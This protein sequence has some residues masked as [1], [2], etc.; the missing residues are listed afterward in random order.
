MQREARPVD[1]CGFVEIVVHAHL[2]EIRRG[3]L[4]VEELVL[5]DEEFA[6]LAGHAQR[7][8]IV[9]DVAPAIVRDQPIGCGEIKTGLPFRGRHFGLRDDGDLGVLVHGWS[10]PWRW[11]FST[12]KAAENRAYGGTPMCVAARYKAHGQLSLQ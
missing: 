7:G 4:G 3:D 10:P 12:P 2:D 1:A 11:N 8:M 5:L 9:D 6:V